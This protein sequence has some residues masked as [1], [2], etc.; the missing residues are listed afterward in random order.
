[1]NWFR[2]GRHR[3]GVITVAELLAE[4]D[5]HMTGRTTIFRSLL[6]VDSLNAWMGRRPISYASE[7]AAITTQYL[8]QMAALGGWAR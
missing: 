4:H 2:R 3:A 6:S 8:S 5:W 1:M 7:R